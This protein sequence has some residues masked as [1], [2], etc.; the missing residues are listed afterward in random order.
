VCCSAIECIAIVPV[1]PTRRL[2]SQSVLQ[3]LAMCCSVFQRVAVRHGT[4]D[5][6]SSLDIP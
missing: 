3:C 1:I 4:C 5:L 6:D 2:V